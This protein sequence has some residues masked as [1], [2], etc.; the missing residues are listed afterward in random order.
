[1]GYNVN[2]VGVK[3]LILATIIISCVLPRELTIYAFEENLTRE[4]GSVISV[5]I[6]MLI[7]TFIILLERFKFR[8]SI[9]KNDTLLHWFVWGIASGIFLIVNQGDFLYYFVAAVKFCIYI[10][11]YNLL[12]RNISSASF[13]KGI[14]IGFRGT[15][16]LQTAIGLLYQLFGIV[17]PFIGNYSTSVRA[18]MIRMVGS[19]NHP[20]DFSLYIAIIS[21]Y[22]VCDFVFKENR[23]VLPYIIMGTIDLLLSGARTM[24]ICTAIV[25]LV[26]ILRKN[27]N[28]PFAKILL[29]LTVAIGIWMFVDS[30]IFQDLFIEHNFLEMLEAR[31]VHWLIGL[32]IMT[33]NVDNF[34][35]GVGLNNCVDYIN[36]NF[37]SFATLL[38]QQV[39]IDDA[40]A[41]TSPIHNSYLI[42]GVETGIFGLILYGRVYFKSIGECITLLKEKDEDI[43]KIVYLM[44]AFFT[45]AVYALQGW[46]LQKNY[47]LTMLVVLSSCLY[48]TKKIDRA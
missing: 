2:K 36:D 30:D 33:T 16:I 22:F 26:I 9:R 44:A 48:H 4:Y 5:T 1:M 34:F 21:L 28:N 32:K 45:Y 35:Y 31:F 38:S 7:M 15:L 18:G 24:L 13:F 41:S 20:G 40:F 42:A 25:S 8:F 46:S 23:N 27:K 10:L 6:P 11:M 43:W 14:D 47:A 39:V 37:G 17:V 19:F 12:S 29:V 3:S